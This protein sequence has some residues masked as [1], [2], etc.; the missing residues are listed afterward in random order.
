MWCKKL[1]GFKVS[2]QKFGGKKPGFFLKTG[3]LVCQPRIIKKIHLDGER[4]QVFQKKPGFS[5]TK[6]RIIAKI[7]SMDV[8]E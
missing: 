1:Y 3:F 4:N 5:S 7:Q 6:P 2:F 8:S